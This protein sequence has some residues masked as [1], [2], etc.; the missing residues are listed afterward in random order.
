MTDIKKIIIYA[1]GW[2]SVLFLLWIYF[3]N[4]K[5]RMQRMLVNDFHMQD[6][7]KGSAVTLQQNSMRVAKWGHWDSVRLSKYF[8]IVKGSLR[9]AI[10]FPG[11]KLNYRHFCY[12]SFPLN[13]GNHLC[14]S[15]GTCILSKKRG[16]LENEIKSLFGVFLLIWNTLWC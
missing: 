4:R 16:K 7:L 11:G 1:E 10:H 6:M 5:R 13:L 14:L 8:R 12:F 9:Y 2:A 3:V 15:S